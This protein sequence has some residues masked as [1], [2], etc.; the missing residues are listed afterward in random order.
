MFFSL[1][2]MLKKKEVREGWSVDNIA[3]QYLCSGAMGV[4]YKHVLWC[5]S[6]SLIPGALKIMSRSLVLSGHQMI[7]TI[8]CTSSAT[9][10]F[11]ASPPN[12]VGAL[13]F[14]FTT[15]PAKHFS[16]SHIFIRT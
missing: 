5:S 14:A 1:S 7:G 8:Q 9:S 6:I 13:T 4:S 15:A 3:L 11:E 2:E 10:P 16:K 12:D